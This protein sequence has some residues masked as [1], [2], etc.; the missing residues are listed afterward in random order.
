[1]A[2]LAI[3]HGIVLNQQYVL[4]HNIGPHLARSVQHLGRATGLYCTEQGV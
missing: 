4:K 3:P 2:V 1:V